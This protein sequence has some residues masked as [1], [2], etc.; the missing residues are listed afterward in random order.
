MTQ[1]QQQSKL[2]AQQQVQDYLTAQQHK[3]L[4]RLLTCGSVDDGKST[5]IG[6]LLH[7]TAQIYDDQLSRLKQ[8]SQR[9]GTTGAELDLALLVDGLQAEREQGITIDV[10]YRYFS[11]EKRK[12]II[13]DAPGHE[14][15]TRNM[16]TGA[17]NCEVAVILI[18]ASSGV[19]T[20]TRRHAFIAAL[21]G[22]RTFVVAVNKM[23]LVDF[24]QSVFEAI[25]NDFAALLQ[26]LP[27][28]GQIPKV[29]CVPL[30]A[31]GGDNVVNR[32][33]NMPWY[34]GPE[35][36]SLLEAVDI[37]AQDTAQPLRFPVQYVNRPDGHFR[38][39]AGT[40]AAGEVAVGDEVLL[41]P[42][43]QCSQ[44]SQIVTFDGDLPR[45]Y[46]GQAVTLCLKDDIDISR[47]DLLCDMNAPAHLATELTVML[48]WLHQSP[49]ALGTLYD[50]K[51]AGRVTQAKITAVD[52]VLD[53]N[54]YNPLPHK[55]IGLNAIAQV[56]LSLTEPLAVDKYVHCRD[57]GGL[58]VIDRL[59]NATL[60]AAMI[61]DI[62]SNEIGQVSTSR[63]AASETGAIS[64][65]ADLSAQQASNE[66]AFSS[67]EL[68][69]NAYIRRYYP[70]WQA[71]DIRKLKRR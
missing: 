48:V 61:T 6:R 40:L 5:L 18:D 41:L 62:A 12:F 37:Q 66:Q 21:L 22:I 50:V 10:A 64:R 13:A 28:A 59:S 9:H 53:I 25:C 57:T 14:Q 2:T 29:E 56:T 27:L 32:S 35:L 58:I 31:L 52:Y 33:K 38:G 3:G 19:Q 24:S 17:S 42:G 70:H 69:L 8:D 55:D 26:G 16:A 46:A 11:S 71:L 43:G 44:V 34:S 49:M 23:D 67:A 54:T 68:E 63:Q 60:A 15:Y 1:S 47:G 4:L 7:D 65:T 36:L 45:A 20:Q 51:L 30:S 39:Y